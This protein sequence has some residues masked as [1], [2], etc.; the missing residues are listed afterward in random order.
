[1]NEPTLSEVRGAVYFPSYAWNSYQT[2]SRYEPAIVSHEVR[3]AARLNLNSLRVYLSY[4]FWRENGP[5][6]LERVDRFLEVCANHGVRPLLSLFEGTPDFRPTEENLT[7]TDPA[8]AKGTHS[9]AAEL[10]NPD[11]S[12]DPTWYGARSPMHYAG[13]IAETVGEDPRLLA[14]ELANEP[15]G[16]GDM[17]AP[18]LRDVHERV[19]DRAP[20]ATVTLGSADLPRGQ[21]GGIT[22]DLDVHQFHENVPTREE[23]EDS[24]DRARTR[25]ERT[26]KPIWLTEW[27]RLDGEHPMR[28]DPAS[29]APIVTAA[30]AEGR[31]Q[32]H[33]LWGLMLKP[34][35]LLGSRRQGRI[36]GLFHRDGAVFQ[37]AAADA[38][39]GFDTGVS[40]YQ[41]YPYRFA[42]H[43]HPY[44]LPESDRPIDS[45]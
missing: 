15:Y 13:V 18:F 37:K 22:S 31:I 40:E 33:Y 45:N 24:L 5:A 11:E 25:H 28:P 20:N 34:A 9:P 32:G 8:T 39:A 38:I 23:L 35:Y 12:G 2:W 17:S 3:Y 6:L 4:E 36:N 26:G 30:L 19:R 42:S 7:D 43:P 10:T 41:G 21:F 14:I 29:M 27:Q 1:M 44:D 16:G